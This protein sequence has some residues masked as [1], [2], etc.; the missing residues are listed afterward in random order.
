MRVTVTGDGIPTK[1]VD[2]KVLTALP[3]GQRLRPGFPKRLGTGGEAPLRYADLNGD[4][5]QELI[6]PLEDGTIHAYRPD[7]SEL[8]GWPVETRDPVLRD[9][10]HAALRPSAT[11]DPPREPP[12]APTIAD[13]DDD[14]SPEVITAAGLRVYVFEADGSL[15]DGFPVRNDPEFCKP[16][17]QRKENSVGGAWHRKCGF[18]AT[19]AVGHVEGADK[20]LDIVAPS[21][22]GHLYVLREDGHAV[23]G[24]PVDL[25][26]PA[27]SAD[28]K[29]YAESIN[30]PAIADIGGG[31]G[32]EP[33]GK[34]D[35]VVPTNEAYGGPSSGD[36][37]VSFAGIL[38][39]AAGQ[40]HARVRSRRCDRRRSCPA[41]RSPSPASSER[42]A[43]DRAGPRPGDRDDRAA[44]RGSSPRRR[45]GRSPPTTRGGEL[46]DTMQQGTSLNLFESA[47]IGDVTGTGG[48]PDVVKYQVEAG[49]AANLLLVGQNV[50]YRHQIGAWDGETGAPLPAT[51][52]STDDY[53]FL[54]GSTIA[55]VDPDGGHEPGRGR[56]GPRPA[57]RLRRRDRP[58]RR[59]ASRR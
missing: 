16:S 36:G 9:R 5:E 28:E 11:I 30:Q 21:L 15:R 58:G 6:A 7:G 23:P 42:P 19:P 26:D 12:R 3:D 35:I 49:Q 24:F 34:D 8:P 14:G 20:P 56:H 40:E 52:P 33:D 59:A 29:R 53:Q 22:D 57:A 47:S 44:R 27:K 10:P 32:N 55:K 43:A 54:S 50:P 41:G 38:G 31:P 45:A 18:L 25:V 37:D 4:N 2:R 1:G 13:L 39:G 51:R 46:Q 17:L 48:D